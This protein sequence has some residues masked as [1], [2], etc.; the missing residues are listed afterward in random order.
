[1]VFKDPKSGEPLV[2]DLD[3]DVLSKLPA[4]SSRGHWLATRAVQRLWE[5]GARV[6]EV[7]GLMAVL[8]ARSTSWARDHT[9]IPAL[10]AE[11]PDLVPKASESEI[12]RRILSHLG[13]LPTTALLHGQPAMS[14]AGAFS[15]CAGILDELPVDT[16]AEGPADGWRLDNSFLPSP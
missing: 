15:W 4:T 7:G 3:R 13:S 9:I 16:S 14:D 1:V 12:T 11:V 6:R 8:R 2:E 10:L 5:R